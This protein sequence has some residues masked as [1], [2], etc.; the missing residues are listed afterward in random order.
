MVIFMDQSDLR[1][2]AWKA[3]RL[4]F[5][6]LANGAV[7]LLIIKGAQWLHVPGFQTFVSGLN[8]GNAASTLIALLIFLVGLGFA[9]F[10]WWLCSRYFQL[11]TGTSATPE[12]LAGLRDLPLA[13]P[14]GTIRAVLA[15][16]VAV[17]GLPLLLF[18]NALGLR[19]AI[20]GYLNGIITGVFAFYFGTRAAGADKQ[21]ARQAVRML[22]NVQNQNSGLA[23]ENAGL[24]DQTQDLQK[25]VESAT[26]ETRSSRLVQELDRVDRQLAVA[27]TIVNLLGPALPEGLIPQGLADLVKTAHTTADNAHK[28]VDGNITEDNVQS[29]AKVADSLIQ[30]LPLKGLLSTAA[31]SLP[32]IAGVPP[33]GAAALVLGIGW[34]LGSAAYRRWR[35]RVLGAPYEPRLIDFG[36]VTGT[37]AQT[38]MNDCPIFHKAFAKEQSPAFFTELVAMMQ[39]DHAPDRIWEKYG[40]DP[41]MFA[42]RGEMQA[43]LDEFR[44]AL[45]ADQSA[46][47]VTDQQITSVSQSLSSAGLGIEPGKVRVEDMNRLIGSVRKDGS[48]D[49]QALQATAAL[50]ALVVLIGQMRDLKI[51]PLKVIA[52]L[53]K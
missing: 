21:T 14:E 38:R 11:L 25:K 53:P 6:I 20:A 40:N 52:E 5:Q 2:E 7:I 51:D 10:L 19:D 13:L 48:G 17:V 12:V 30:A 27:D 29:V 46:Q 44:L 43:G 22:E 4:P 8:Q 34:Q 45:L 37:S 35:A 36:Q 41:S 15:L 33:L 49:V 16:I 18:S 47:D 31:G 26:T 3:F 42:S 1:S 32:L 24:K 50:H 9:T 23:T 28:L 39:D